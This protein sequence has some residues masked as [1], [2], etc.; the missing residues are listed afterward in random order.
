MLKPFLKKNGIRTVGDEHFKEVKLAEKELDQRMA[1]R[2]IKGSSSLGREEFSPNLFG[3]LLSILL[4]L[5]AIGTVLCQLYALVIGS[6]FIWS[7]IS[8]ILTGEFLFR[9]FAGYVNPL[10]FFQF[11]PGLGNAFLGWGVFCSALISKGRIPG[12]TFS[13]L[14]VTSFGIAHLITGL[15]NLFGIQADIAIQI[16]GLFGSFLSVILGFIIV[17]T[18]LQAWSGKNS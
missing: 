12:K 9:Y 14:A 16:S 6:L 4:V 1:D 18:I 17:S 15:M 11:N 8:S 2:G 3:F 7:G 5:I 10:P 13:M